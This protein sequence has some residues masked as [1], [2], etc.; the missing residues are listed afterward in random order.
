MKARQR[1]LCNIIN[2]L[3]ASVTTRSW[4]CV[5]CSSHYSENKYCVSCGTGIY[6]FEQSS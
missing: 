6:S 3:D 5:W 2:W 4:Y 1:N